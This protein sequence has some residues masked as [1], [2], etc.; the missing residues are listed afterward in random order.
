MMH[1]EMPKP[2][3][4][5]AQT[6]KLPAVSLPLISVNH[7]SFAVPFPRKTAS[8]FVN[9]LGFKILKRPDAFEKSFDG[10]WV[11]GMGLEVHFIQPTAPS[12]SATK[13]H[14]VHDRLLNADPNLP[15]D[16][17]NDHLSFL[18]TQG[19]PN[20]AWDT[21]V[22]MLEEA[23]VRYIERSFPK[24]DLRQLFFCDPTSGIL[25]EISTN[26]KC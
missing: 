2:P 17:R 5:A 3:V 10:A 8:F 1:S 13:L 21:I 22:R 9:V 23:N 15:I 6:C 11:C 18:C 20:S 4:L 12:P 24:D 25:I 14:H 26:P 19:S 7:I 16:P